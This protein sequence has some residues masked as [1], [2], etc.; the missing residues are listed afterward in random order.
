MTSANDM[1]AAR[2]TYEGFISMIKVSVPVIALIVAFVIL[3]IQ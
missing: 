3:I 2:E 1:K